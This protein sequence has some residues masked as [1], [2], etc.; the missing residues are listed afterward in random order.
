MI[1]VFNASMGVFFKYFNQC[2]PMFFA[3]VP[4][5]HLSNPDCLHVAIYK[6]YDLK[7]ELCFR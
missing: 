1:I 3:Y 2:F 6:S 7:S 4:P 5:N